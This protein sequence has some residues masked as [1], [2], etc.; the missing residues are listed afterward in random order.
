MRDSDQ[1]RQRNRRTNH[2]AFIF[3]KLVF[4]FRKRVRESKNVLVN[5]FS[6]NT[7]GNNMFKHWRTI[8][9]GFSRGGEGVMFC[10]FVC[11]FS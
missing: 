3:I 11:L 9:V 4:N 5:N 6:K 10:L 2:E 7:V 8:D 1:N